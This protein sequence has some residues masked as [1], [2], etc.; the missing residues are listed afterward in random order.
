NVD[1]V[2]IT[3]NAGGHPTLRPMTLGEK[4]LNSEK[5][6][7]IH[8][9]CKDMNRNALESNAWSLSSQ[10]FNNILALTGD[11]PQN[12]Y[13]GN[14][15]PVFDFD[16]VSLL[17]M[18][19]KLNEGLTTGIK[20]K[21]TLKST[22]FFLGATVSNNKKNENELIPQYL[23]LKEKIKN[24]AEFIIPQV[25]FDSGKIQELKLF[26]HDNGFDHIPLVGNIYLLSKFTSNLFHKNKIPGIVLTDEL[27]NKCQHAATSDDK[28][29]SFFIEFAAKMLNIFKKLGYKGAYFGGIHNY[30]NFNR[31]IEV[32]KSFSENDNLDF[33]KELWFPKKNEYFIYKKDISTCLLQKEKNLK[34]KNKLS[35]KSKINYSVSKGFHSLM[36]KPGAIG[37]KIGKTISNQ[38]KYKYHLPSWIHIIEKRSKQVIYDCKDC[39]D[40]ALQYTGYLCPESQCPKGLRNGPCGGTHD[41]ICEVRDSECIW[42]RAYNRLK[43]DKKE[44]NL[45]DHT[46]AFKDN[47]LV[48]TSAWA[49]YWLEKDFGSKLNKK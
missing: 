34:A 26:M 27:Y 5:E 40:C 30:D 42:S 21:T 38:D 35:F 15:K 37:Y 32:E 10:G 17:N 8:L 33:I 11:Y 19:S 4:F 45:L 7:I 29:K 23:K 24:G 39:G 2:S 43:R 47:S 31:I 36:F 20:K 48:D 28:G 46:P 13:N 18:L 22:D 9:T 49:N 25:G 3:D 41:S 44:N 6:V 16:S 1:W 12:G 14:S